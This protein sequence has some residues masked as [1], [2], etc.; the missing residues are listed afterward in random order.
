MALDIG[1]KRIG[2]A[3]SD[4]LGITAL[5][6]TVIERGR[7]VKAD[8]RAVE[9]LVQEH[10]V[11]KVVVGIPIMLDGTPG[12]QAGKVRAFAEKLAR[13]LR[14]SVVEWD[15]RMTTLE[16][17][18]ALIAA[19]RSR[20]ERKKVIDKLAATLILQSYLDAHEERV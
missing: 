4:E 8:L 10:D 2:V 13:R 19:D 12:V 17:E 20:A 18:K 14:V 6:V 7:S 16:A 3:I 1:E 9:Q 5:P 15:E 11:S